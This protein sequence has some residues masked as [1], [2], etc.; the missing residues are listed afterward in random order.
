MTDTTTSPADDADDMEGLAVCERCEATYDPNESQSVVTGRTGTGHWQ[1][2]EWCPD[3]V[4][5]DTVRLED[6][7]DAWR[8]LPT[9]V[10]AYGTAC[11][12]FYCHEPDGCWYVY[13]QDE[14][15][16]EDGDSLLD[17]STDVLD[18]LGWPRESRR[19]ALLFGV[20]LEMEAKSHY[21]AHDLVAQL[22][23]SRGTNSGKAILKRDGS[24]E[25]GRGVELVTLPFT[26]ERHTKSGMWPEMLDA[27]LQAMAKSGA[28]TTN[29]GIHVHINRVALSP[30][31]VGKLVVFLNNPDNA[32]FCSD[33]AQ[34]RS[35]GYC[36]RDER[37][38]ITSAHKGYTSLG[39]QTVTGWDGETHTRE[40]TLD[41][42]R[43]DIINVTGSRTVE[44]RMFRGNLRPERVLKNIEFCHALVRFC[45]ASSI[46]SA[47]RFGHFIE[48]LQKNRR[49]YP[50]LVDFLT[51][52]QW[53]PPRIVRG[54]PVAP[55]TISEV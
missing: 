26:L 55:A 37:K 15:E 11:E 46:K 36:Q 41:N 23:G 43:Y 32:S 53:M 30:L 27:R 44:I 13:P 2:Q 8:P 24:L 28:G 19:D 29:C 6:P 40:V 50:N 54:Q 10:V 38:K 42:S 7:C 3:C 51:E 21:R 17:Y 52:K 33:V 39:T 9:D 12:H 47:A 16:D 48:W 31:T 14:D 45:E 35:G 18:V 4:S 25:D 1:T 34:R 5:N 22:G 49:E 20:E